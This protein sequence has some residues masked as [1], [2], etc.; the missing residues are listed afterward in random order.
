MTEFFRFGNENPCFL[1]YKETS[2]RDLPIEFILKFSWNW[3]E[4][5]KPSLK[6]K[7][8]LFYHCNFFFKATINTVDII[9]KYWQDYQ[10]SRKGL[11]YRKQMR[12]FQTLFNSS[13]PP[14]SYYNGWFAP[15]VPVVSCYSPK[16]HINIY[17]NTCAH[18]Q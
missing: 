1:F 2:S 14:F 6:R 7:F 8:H 18:T 16:V 10:I 15:C 12:S 9:R 5:K 3:I 17:P 11:I 4:F 13:S